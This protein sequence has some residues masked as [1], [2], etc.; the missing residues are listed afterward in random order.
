M[1]KQG[2]ATVSECAPKNAL[3]PPRHVPTPCPDS[4]DALR[5]EALMPPTSREERTSQAL[6]E[7]VREL[8]ST[9]EHRERQ[10]DAMRR[11]SDALFSHSEVDDVVRETLTV[12]ID[13]LRGDSG[14][15][16]L[17]SSV[18]DTLV[19]KYVIGPA[20][21]TLTG[22]AMPSSQGIAGRVFGTG[23]PDLT[24]KV[25]EQADFNSEV[26]KKTGYHTESMMTVPVKR[27]DGPPLGV[28]QILNTESHPFD[29]R[30]LEVLEV[31]SAVAASAIENARL[32]QAARKATLVNIIGDISHDIKNMLTPIQT[33]VW[34]L[35]PLLDEMFRSLDALR[36]RDES[37]STFGEELGD[38]MSM[39]QE[40]YGWILEN[41]LDAAEKVQARTKE[42]ADAV[43]GHSAPPRFELDNINETAQDV[44]RALRLVA[45]DKRI[46]LALDL[47]PNLPDTEFDSKQIYNALYNLVN[48]AIPETPAGGSITVRTRPPAEGEDTLLIEVADTGRGI[49]EKVRV[50]LFTDAAIS[51]KP[52]GTGFGTRIV[53]D[54]VRR[55]HGTISVESVEGQGSTFIVR[56]PLR[57]TP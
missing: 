36:T 23:Q 51:T 52:G 42:I 25:S 43:K 15:L 26:D 48:N 20:A 21:A 40:D 30:D 39:V 55:H 49:P 22:F 31:L 29:E 9:L 17:H 19:F 37:A 5:R 27:A 56:L 50:L 16:L 18:D 8:E 53:A 3:A 44:G 33:G 14:S 12:A 47:A 34:T 45:H 32:E 11:T 38:A 41:A 4:L 54:I 13:V 2:V 6:A 57:Q 7:R 35:Q 46:E 10:I 28:M 1:G 24:Q